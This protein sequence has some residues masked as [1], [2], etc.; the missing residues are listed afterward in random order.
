MVIHI[1]ELTGPSVKQL[2]NLTRQSRDLDFRVIYT[3]IIVID[4]VTLVTFE[5]ISNILQLILLNI[6]FNQFYLNSM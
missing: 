3:H 1:I 6:N 4:K 5:V 2:A